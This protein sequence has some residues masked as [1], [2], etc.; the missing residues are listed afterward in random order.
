MTLGAEGPG[1]HTLTLFRAVIMC[2]NFPPDLFFDI[3]LLLFILLRKKGADRG[4]SLAWR[5]LH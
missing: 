3:K 1:H 2:H 5:I 4:D